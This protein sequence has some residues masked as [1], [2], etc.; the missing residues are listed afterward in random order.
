MEPTPITIVNHGLDSQTHDLYDVQ[1]GPITVR[2]LVT[3][4]ASM[5]DSWIEDIK[6]INNQSLGHLI[7]GLDVE[8]RP[9]FNRYIENPVAIIQ[10]CV[11]PRCLIFQLLHA[12]SVPSSLAEFLGNADYSFVGVGVGADVEKLLVDYQLSV[13]K[14]VELG[15]LAANKYGDRSLKNAGLKR[16]ASFVLGMQIEKPKRITM[17]RW[18]NPYLNSSQVQYACVDA[19]LSFEIGK[20]LMT[21]A[22]TQV[23]V[24]GQ[25]RARA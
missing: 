19:Y 10:L 4:S 12:D 8:W 18:D 16:L 3:I 9:S 1:V 5:V 2:T 22:E 14:P 13:R 25:V 11:G 20:V 17:S 15:N 21:E 6:R 23:P 7:V 24:A